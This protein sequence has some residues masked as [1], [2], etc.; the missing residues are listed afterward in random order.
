ML[1]IPITSTN[2]L[3]YFIKMANSTLFTFCALISAVILTASAV[4]PEEVCYYNTQKCCYGWS[5]CG[6]EQ[7]KVEEKYDCPYQKC[8]A[9]CKP[10]CESKE[11]CA[12]KQVGKECHQKY[13]DGHYKLVCTP[14]FEKVCATEEVCKDVC[15]PHCHKVY[16]KCLK[17]LHY[18]YAKY[19]PNLHCHELKVTEGSSEEP[20]VVIDKEGKLKDTVD[21]GRIETATETAEAVVPE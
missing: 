11:H 7:K 2:S 13:V 16:A 12:E 21:A 15:K 18:E 14:K 6:Y 17:H 1:T 19:C 8:A 10:H 9:V 20:Q 4:A 5:H 3:I